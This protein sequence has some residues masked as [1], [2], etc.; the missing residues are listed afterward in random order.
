MKEDSSEFD[1]LGRN[2][3]PSFLGNLD[4]LSNNSSFLFCLFLDMDVFGFQI[5]V[6][7]NITNLSHVLFLTV[8]TLLVMRVMY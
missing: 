2:E 6:V 4:N 5:R 1:F 8:K 7:D 3:T